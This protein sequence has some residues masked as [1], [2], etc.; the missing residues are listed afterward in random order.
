MNEIKTIEEMTNREVV[1]SLE[2]E[3]LKMPQLDLPIKH[4]FSPGLYAREL[5]IPAGTLLTGKVHK[6]EH[7]NIMSQGDMSV[8]TENGI[9]RVQAPFT[10]VSPAGTKR[11]AFAHADTVWTTIHATEETDLDKIEDLLVANS[12]AE[13]SEFIL[14]VMENKKCLS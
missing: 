2:I 13:Y 4:Y 8:L 10:I 11:I 12:D 1:N 5:F 3:M 7:L 6:F 14:A 9:K